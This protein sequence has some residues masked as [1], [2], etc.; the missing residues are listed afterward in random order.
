MEEAR[1]T[2]NNNETDILT[3]LEYFK[4]GIKGIFKSIKN[5][6][7]SII[8]S[9]VWLLLLIK[10][11]VLLFAICILAFVVFS[12]FRKNI[13]GEKFAYE[14]IVKPNYN[15]NE[16]LYN[17][18]NSLKSK[19]NKP[20]GLPYLNAI[21]IEPIT[22]INQQVDVFYSLIGNEFDINSGLKQSNDRD[23]LIYR[24][25]KFEDFKDKIADEDYIYQ[26]INIKSSKKLSKKELY[27]LIVQPIE[28]MEMFKRYKTAYLKSLDIGLQLNKK[29]LQRI[30]TLLLQLSNR[31]V[32]N[33]SSISLKAESKNNVEEDLFNQYSK[34]SNAIINLENKKALYNKVINV[35]SD[36]NE[37]STKRFSE[38]NALVYA[39]YGFLFALLLVLLLRLW[40]YLALLE[41]K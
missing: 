17:I 13:L 27:Q 29:G 16:A 19:A 10:K 38:Q 8:N 14:M 37:I 33:L 39:I 25:M 3:L 31:N 6:F 30:D 12:F 18:V 5:F 40:N 1:P 24:Q 23:T 11:N 26:K 32:Q 28:D 35:V 34:Y 22:S 15:S 2:Q 21:D 41:K 9:I 7:G 36:G 4:N 20:E